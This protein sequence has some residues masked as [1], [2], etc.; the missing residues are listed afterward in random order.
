MLQKFW[1]KDLILIHKELKVYYP[2]LN[3]PIAY[4]NVFV[5]IEVSARSLKEPSSPIREIFFFNI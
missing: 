4:I 5:K 1:L 2:S 3:D